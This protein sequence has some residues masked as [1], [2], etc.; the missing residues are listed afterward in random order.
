MTF[1]VE[2]NDGTLLPPVGGLPERVV[3]TVTDDQGIASVRWILGNEA[4]AGNHRVRAVARDFAGEALFCAVALPGQATFVH[5][6]NLPRQTAAVRGLTPEP[7][8]V[9]VHDG[10]NGVRNVPVTFKVLEG[11]GLVDGQSQ[12]TVVSSETGNA[13]VVFQCGPYAGPQRVEASFAGQVKGRAVFLVNALDAGAK[14]TTSFTGEVLD[15]AGRGIGAAPVQLVVNGKPQTPVITDPKGRFVFPNVSES[16]AG[17]LHIETRLATQLDGQPIP[18]GSFPDMEFRPVIVPLTENTLGETIRIPPLDP[19]SWRIVDNTQDVELTVPEL[20]GLSFVVKKGSM[21]YRGVLASPTNP[22]PVSVNQVHFDEVPMPLPNGTALPFAWTLQPAG[23]TFDPPIELRMPNM[24]GL[25]PGALC[26]FLSYDHDVERFDIVATGAVSDDGAQLVSDPGTGIAKA[27]WGGACPPYPN[28]GAMLRDLCGDDIVDAVTD[29][30]KKSGRQSISLED[31]V[32]ELIEEGCGQE[33]GGGGG[34]SPPDWSNDYSENN[35]HRAAD[36]LEDADAIRNNMPAPFRDPVGEQVPDWVGDDGDMSDDDASFLAQNFG[37]DPQW[38]DGPM[39]ADSIPRLV[40]RGWTP[41]RIR[42]EHSAWVNNAMRNAIQTMRNSGRISGWVADAALELAPVQSLHWNETLLAMAPMLRPVNKG[43]VSSYPTL[44]AALTRGQLESPTLAAR[45]TLRVT[46]PGNAF[47]LPVG[48][49]QTY[50]LAVRRTSDNADLTLGS[51]GTK[52]FV[53]DGSQVYS[54]TSDGLLS[55]PLLP[56]SLPNQAR[57]LHIFVRNGTDYGIGQFAVTDRDTDGDMIV[58][59]W[60][61]L[62]GLNPFVDQGK[63]GDIDQDGLRDAHECVIGSNPNVFDSDRDGVRDGDEVEQ[64]S[65]VLNSLRT[66][67]EVDSSFEV[68][69]GTQR[70]R[71]SLAGSWR[72]DNVPINLNPV[73]ARLRGL[74]AGQDAFAASA[75]VDIVGNNGRVAAPMQAVSRTRILDPVKL[76][77]TSTR[78]TFDQLGQ[79]AALKVEANY[80]GTAFSDVTLRTL[81]TRYASSNPRILNVD[82]AGGLTARGAGVV[83]VTATNEGVSTTT[84]AFVSPGDLF[85]TVEGFVYLSDQTPAQAATV[86]VQPGGL[87][88]QTDQDGRFRFEG[89]PTKLG[90]IA[91]SAY[92]DVA[93]TMLVG[94]ADE[95]DVMPGGITDAGVIT[96]GRGNYWTSDAGGD[97]HDATKWSLQRVPGPDDIAVINRPSPTTTV[98]IRTPVHVRAIVNTERLYT[99]DGGVLECDAPIAL[100]GTF[101]LYNSGRWKGIR[102]APGSGTATIRGPG[103]LENCSIG[104]RVDVFA[105][106]VV[107]D[108]G[109]T[110]DGNLVLQNVPLI[111]PGNR[112]IDG[113]GAITLVRSGSTFATLASSGGSLTIGPS[114][115]VQGGGELGIA[116]EGLVIEGTVV[117]F[118]GTLAVRGAAWVCNGALATNGTGRLALEDDGTLRGNVDNPGGICDVNA[119]LD[120]DGGARTVIGTISIRSTGRARNGRFTG[121]DSTVICSNGSILED[122]VLDGTVTMPA[123]AIVHIA[124]RGLTINGVASISGGQ[125]SSDGGYFRF[126]GNQVLDGIGEVRMLPGTNS[127]GMQLL[128][129]TTLR[130]GAEL[131]IH[132]TGEIEGDATTRVIFDGRLSA[133]TANRILWLRAPWSCSGS[134]EATTGTLIV[135]DA[136]TSTGRI[137]GTGR[138]VFYKDVD[139]ASTTTEVSGTLAFR[140]VLA[141]GTLTGNGKLVSDSTTGAVLDSMRVACAAE[142]PQSFLIT[143]RNGLVLDG[144][145][146][147]LPGSSGLYTRLAFEG[148]QSV[149]GTGRIEFAGSS[150]WREILIGAAATVD[151]GPGIR[152]DGNGGIVSG[153]TLRVDGTIACTGTNQTK[154]ITANWECRGAV[155]ASAGG[156]LYFTGDGTLRGANL[157]VEPGSQLR[158]GDV[159][160]AGA[161]TTLSGAME[162]GGL[163]RNGTLTGPGSASLVSESAFDG[164]TCGIDVGWSVWGLTV[165]NS[166]VL[167]AATLRLDNGSS[168]LHTRLLFEGTQTVSGSGEIHANG[169][170]V[171][172]DLSGAA[173]SKVTI[174]AGIPIRGG[175]VR[176]SIVDMTILGDI[177]CESST[178]Q[179]QGP[180]QHSGRLEAKNDGQL[181]MSGAGIKTGPIV[182]SGTAGLRLGNTD[183]QNTVVSVTGAIE[184]A[185]TIANGTLNG[186]GASAVYINSVL[187]NIVLQIPCTVSQRILDLDAVTLDSDIILVNGNSNARST[188]RCL[189]NQTINGS[190]SILMPGNGPFR[191]IT[192]NAGVTVR[193]GPGVEIRGGDTQISVPNLE[194]DGLLESNVDTRQVNVS[195]TWLCRGTLR[196]VG[197]ARLV[198]TA[199]GT[200][201]GASL[202]CASPGQLEVRGLE[203]GAST[204]T[205]T[206]Q[207]RAGGTIQNGTLGGTG[208]LFF[209]TNSTLSNLQL[210]CNA[211]FDGPQVTIAGLTLNGTMTARGTTTTGIS[212]VY[213]NGTQT[214]LGSGKIAMAGTTRPTAWGGTTTTTITLGPGLTLENTSGSCALGNRPF[215]N[216]GTIEVLAGRL[217]QGTALTAAQSNSGTL[218]VRGGELE[219]SGLWTNSGAVIV[220]SGGTLDGVNTGLDLVT[221]TLQN[222]GAVTGRWTF[223][224]GILAGSGTTT[225]GQSSV[226]DTMRLDQDVLAA[227][228]ITVRGSLVVNGV[229][230]SRFTTSGTGVVNFVGSTSYDVSG[231]GKI[232]LENATFALGNN[233]TLRLATG[234]SLE[235][236]GSITS[237]G[238]TPRFEC[239]GTLAANVATRTLRVSVDFFDV[240]PGGAV[241]VTNGATLNLDASTTNATNAG[242]LFVEAG[243]RV[244]ASLAFTQSAGTT[245][246]DG[247]RAFGQATSSLR[248]QGGTLAGS[249]TISL[250]SVVLDGRLEPGGANATGVLTIGASLTC[251]STAVIAVELAGTTVGSGYDRVAVAGTLNLTGTLEVALVG[252]YVP[253]IPDPFDVL[254]WGTRN[255]SFATTNGLTLPGSKKLVPTYGTSALTLTTANQ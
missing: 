40:E 152:F 98:W 78:T 63:D 87:V 229:L 203:L 83:F 129:G 218:R 182:Q 70:A 90:T 116:T 5:V 76:R 170:G 107:I 59:S 89:I 230:T 171:W 36:R 212:T 191:D 118:Q 31:F 99:T 168:G 80:G 120:L 93:G 192:A 200:L 221:S 18:V 58:D 8:M 50:Q 150:I 128:A 60:E 219:L 145:L 220:D 190:G 146:R 92:K 95:L 61:R 3:Q 178:M 72:V 250:G 100:D 12:A 109:L 222:D 255:G 19:A 15:N 193:F 188:L 166:L 25:A 29:R 209:F 132:G 16:G 185:G 186:T 240:R 224:N 249:G 26:Y 225:L 37:Q 134:L 66:S 75:Y 14:P 155:T 77:S 160:F 184:L 82:N 248:I 207:V 164:M 216:Q 10:C 4:G 69:V 251:S 114:L 127:N 232:V 88:T 196:T 9:W 101:D 247:T 231:S 126:S 202:E 43:S 144:H 30:L 201:L 137:D 49:T 13:S 74:V 119:V 32:Q 254:T 148:T 167:D 183:L 24:G 20:P 28:L 96:L 21:R 242:T 163:L 228:T 211:A 223:T 64:G 81:G 140:G 138:V 199:N 123:G 23:A 180:W 175:F 252:T 165:R 244:D 238:T 239:S 113:S 194:V 56:A 177:L 139:F 65:D 33:Q 135:D 174:A 206:G 233:A 235:G 125:F 204:S 162:I 22:I 7:L 246:I 108:G 46:A 159:D 62:T 151:F 53:S 104:G 117:A 34:G 208:E 241:S 198:C 131:W 38:L 217:Y 1:S 48:P 68:Q 195:G 153:G 42:D 6:A 111:L 110:V 243:S 84:P 130:C 121:N 85:T 11:G 158:V 205:V 237:A 253:D 73:R 197:T 234:M 210:D 122:M 44:P 2:R 187:S 227:S 41:A 154:R 94:V 124:G 115:T 214:I 57:K 103:T 112:R 27:G 52:Y 169:T 245:T 97:F 35:W 156:Y 176:V 136:G 17:L 55:T 213:V 91:V 173:G 157:A 149:S 47:F 181:I 102:I 179:F 71:A 226:L 142:I 172:K 67:P 51:T 79:R 189:T 147:M 86:V 39:Q 106:G 45:G 54:V 133:D 105:A 141:N 143:V 236:Y 161:T 215:V